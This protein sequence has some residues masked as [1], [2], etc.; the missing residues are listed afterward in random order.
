M[1]S[2]L[3]TRTVFT[4]GGSGRATGPVTR[5][6]SCP[7]RA[8]AT[9]HAKPI[10]PLEGLE[11]KRTSSMYSRVGPAVTRTLI[12]GPRGA[13]PRRHGEGE[14]RSRASGSPLLRVRRSLQDGL[15]GLQDVGG[16]REP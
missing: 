11:R 4:P 8:A 13:E 2:A 5:V 12:A 14:A 9:A 15:D 16:L 6:T 7:A 10:L 3:S 1:S